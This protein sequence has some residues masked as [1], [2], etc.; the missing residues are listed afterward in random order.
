MSYNVDSESPYSDIDEPELY[1]GYKSPADEW[2]VTRSSLFRE[3]TGSVFR[4]NEKMSPRLAK[5]NEIVAFTQNKDTQKVIKK[6]YID[7]RFNFLLEFIPEPIYYK[8]IE[9]M[10]FLKADKKKFAKDISLN[11]DTLASILSL[12]QLELHTSGNFV[13][14]KTLDE[15]NVFLRES[16]TYADFSC[17]GHITSKD[18]ERA[19]GRILRQLYNQTVGLNE[20]LKLDKNL[21]IL[22]YYKEFMNQMDYY[23]NDKYKKL[24]KKKSVLPFHVYQLV[25]K[26]AL[27]KKILPKVAIDYFKIYIEPEDFVNLE[28]IIDKF[29]QEKNAMVGELISQ[30]IILLENYYNKT[31]QLVDMPQKFMTRIKKYRSEFGEE[32]KILQEHLTLLNESLVETFEDDLIITERDE[33]SKLFINENSNCEFE[34]LK[35]PEKI[36]RESF[37]EPYNEDRHKNFGLIFKFLLKKLGIPSELFD[38]IQNIIK[39]IR[40]RINTRTILNL[41]SVLITISIILFGVQD[42]YHKFNLLEQKENLNIR[43]KIFQVLYMKPS[44]TNENSEVLRRN[45]SLIIK[46]M[47]QSDYLSIENVCFG[48]SFKLLDSISKPILNQRA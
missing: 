32:F 7:D 23:L 37:E 2:Q 4:P 9:A 43:E 20:E 8:I 36:Y 28:Y 15:I 27:M 19:E 45:R 21:P 6:N 3:F 30:S 5:L 41:F 42:L 17:K 14:E 13:T 12:W 46:N 48:T 10:T 47:L 18:I 1:Q 33:Q 16:S 25:Q 29:Y 11:V 31:A 39:K 40:E 44:N 26:I 24:L 38:S 22:T 35:S 34:E